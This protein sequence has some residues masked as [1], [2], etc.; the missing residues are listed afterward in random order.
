MRIPRPRLWSPEDPYL[1]DLEVRLLRSGNTVDAV[2]SYFGMRKIEVRAD[3][4]GIARLF[5]NNQ[6]LYNL[7]VLNKG[8][9]R[10]ESTPRPP[11]QP[12][13]RC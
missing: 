12:Q 3:N 10:M 5:L 9:G 11:M 4:T 2:Q 8:I 7:G 1:Y 6:Y 13:V